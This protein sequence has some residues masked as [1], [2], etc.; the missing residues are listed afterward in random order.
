MKKQENSFP[1]ELSY[2]KDE[3]FSW[4][5]GMIPGRNLDLTKINSVNNVKNKGK[6]NIFYLLLTTVQDN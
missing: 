3:S 2:K 6:Y 4:R 1:V 5:K